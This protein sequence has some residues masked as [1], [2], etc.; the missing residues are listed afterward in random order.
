MFCHGP[1]CEHLT[2]KLGVIADQLVV[3]S[4]QIVLHESLQQWDI[5]LFFELKRPP[6]GA[7]STDPKL[8]QGGIHSNPV[9][10]EIFPYIEPLVENF[11]IFLNLF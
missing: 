9:G 8:S 4:G 10:H 3:P 2:Q 7:H 1:N 11:F 6:P 5:K